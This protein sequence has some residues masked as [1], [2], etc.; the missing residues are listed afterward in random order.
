MIVL[1]AVCLCLSRGRPIVFACQGESEERERAVD[2]GE[3][4]QC[5]QFYI[6]GL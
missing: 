4:T 5:W 1:H 2:S 3:P 6:L